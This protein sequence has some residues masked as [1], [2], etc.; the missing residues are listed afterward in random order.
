MIQGFI[1]GIKEKYEDFKSKITDL[2]DTIS[3]FLHF[4][5]PDK[6]PLANYE[7]WMPDFMQGMAQGIEKNRDLIKNAAKNVAN[8]ISNYIPTEIQSNA[9]SGAIQQLNN[10]FNIGTVNANSE[11]DAENFAKNVS[12]LLYN[13]IVRSKR[14]VYA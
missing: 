8:D 5:S 3:E 4:S 13:D 6:G 2:A 9:K 14:G 1:D 12:K 10:I 11:K 7:T